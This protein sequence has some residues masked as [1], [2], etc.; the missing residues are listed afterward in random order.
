[1]AKHGEQEICNQFEEYYSNDNEVDDKGIAKS[2]PEGDHLSEEAATGQSDAQKGLPSGWEAIHDPASGDYYYN[3]W[4]TGEVTW[5]RPPGEYPATENADPQSTNQDSAPAPMSQLKAG[6]AG[7]KA[8]FDVG[9]HTDDDDRSA[10]TEDS[11]PSCD[12]KPAA[13]VSDDP[14]PLVQYNKNSTRNNSRHSQQSDTSENDYVFDDQSSTSSGIEALTGALSS[15]YKPSASGAPSP[16][17]GEDN[18]TIEE[19]DMIVWSDD[20]AEIAEGTDDIVPLQPITRSRS[21]TSLKKQPW[22]QKDDDN[23]SDCSSLVYE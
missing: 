17:L 19:D 20:E 14:P 5:D 22:H 12:K 1:L 11:T 3:N 7:V 23:N 16:T 8:I 4:E 18:A 13:V 10:V 6:D 15:W 9:P 2:S 21:G